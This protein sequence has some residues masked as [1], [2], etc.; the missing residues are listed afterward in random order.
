MLDVL[1]NEGCKE[2]FDQFIRIKVVEFL[3]DNELAF[4][5]FELGEAVPTGE[6]REEYQRQLN[7]LRKRDQYAMAAAD[8]LI[9][10]ASAVLGV[11]ILIMRTDT[12]DKHMFDL[13]TPAALGAELKHNSPIFL[14]FSAAASHYEEARPL[15]AA[16]EAKLL[17]VQ[18]TYLK[19]N[20]WPHQYGTENDPTHSR[21]SSPNESGGGSAAYPSH[22]KLVPD[23]SDSLPLAL[24]QEGHHDETG[25][26]SPTVKKR[27][28]DIK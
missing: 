12:P 10:G 27:D 8:L 7:E 2:G 1:D 14:M 13:H 23:N 25:Q 19:H 11:N 4:E 3:W 17:D 16:S 24:P 21:K 9:D 28:G 5:R 6:R 15:D 20:H 22:K 26:H 18:E